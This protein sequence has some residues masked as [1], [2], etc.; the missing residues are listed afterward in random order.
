LFLLI[1]SGFVLGMAVSIGWGEVTGFGG[2]FATASLYVPVSFDFSE[3]LRVPRSWMMLSFLVGVI[4][5]LIVNI[6]LILR[7][8]ISLLGGQDRLKDIAPPEVMTE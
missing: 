1:I 5:L 4:L 3:W 2:R 7:T 6:E 8:V